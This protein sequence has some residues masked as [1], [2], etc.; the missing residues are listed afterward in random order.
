MFIEI[1]GP[2]NQMA[3]GLHL[4]LY[5]GRN[6]ATYPPSVN[7]TGLSF[8]QGIDAASGIGFLTV[9]VS[10]MRKGNQVGDGIAL[11]VDTTSCFQ[12]VSY[13]GNFTAQSGPCAGVLSADVGMSEPR[14]AVEG[15]SIQLRGTG[16]TFSDFTWW[17][18]PQPATPGAVNHG[19]QLVAGS[20]DAKRNLR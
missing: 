2:A 1:A 14:H 7:L 16:S 8:D 5:Q 19:Q 3:S 17:N 11:S 15:N 4:Y 13:G 6:G 18:Q 10:W 20:S 12:F 9:P